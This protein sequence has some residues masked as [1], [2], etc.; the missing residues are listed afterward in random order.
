MAAA[1]ARRSVGDIDA[2]D[3]WCKPQPH[4]GNLALLSAADM[5]SRCSMRHQAFNAAW[6]FGFIPPSMTPESIM[7]ND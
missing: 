4:K 2:S 6:T 1:I 7:L 5:T 3:T